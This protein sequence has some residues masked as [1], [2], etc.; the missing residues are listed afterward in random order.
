MSTQARLLSHLLS[1]ACHSSDIESALLSLSPF[2]SSP[3]SPALLT[4]PSSL[5]DV[6]TACIFNLALGSCFNGGRSLILTTRETIDSS[7]HPSMKSESATRVQIKYL[8]NLSELI[9]YAAYLHLLPEL[10]HTVIV[11]GLFRSPG[12]RQQQHSNVEEQLTMRA[13]A[14]LVDASAFIRDKL[15]PGAQVSLLVAEEHGPD[16]RV[17]RKFLFD[18]WTPTALALTASEA[19]SHQSPIPRSISSASEVS[20]A[21]E[22]SRSFTLSMSLGSKPASLVLPCWMNSETTIERISSII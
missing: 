7:D 9:K 18:R 17:A 3:C 22:G 14:T 15:G 1:S 8:S 19:S 11:F 10:P 13:L 2:L 21:S 16:D 6:A 20:S 12:S 4:Y 5:K